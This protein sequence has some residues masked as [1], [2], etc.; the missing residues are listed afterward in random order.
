VAG[1]ILPGLATGTGAVKKLVEAI[2]TRYH[3]AF[4]NE[5]RDSL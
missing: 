3:S 5:Y 2:R 4:M 1:L